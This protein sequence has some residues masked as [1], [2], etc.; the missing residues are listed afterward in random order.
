MRRRLDRSCDRFRARRRLYRSD[1]S[2]R[3]RLFID[4]TRR[5]ARCRAG[6]A[7]LSRPRRPSAASGGRFPR[8]CSCAR[9]SRPPS[10]QRSRLLSRLLRKTARHRSHRRR[11]VALRLHNHPMLASIA[12]YA[13][14]ATTLAGAAALLRRR[15]RRTGVA[16]IAGGV[17]LA[18]TALFW[19]VPEEQVVSTTTTHLDDAMPRWQF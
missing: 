3:Y 2:A 4:R 19:P 5:G 10:H 13:G 8:R 9:A 6:M 18:A 16:L 17:G 14:G 1:G 12:L 11:P 7:A 15:T